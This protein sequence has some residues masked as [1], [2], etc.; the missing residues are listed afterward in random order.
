MLHYVIRPVAQC[1]RF[2]QHFFRLVFP[3][4]CLCSSYLQSSRFVPHLV[5]LLCLSPTYLQ[6]S[7]FV[8]GFSACPQPTCKAAGLCMASSGFSACPQ[9]N[10]KAADLW[11]QLV[12]L[13][14]FD[15]SKGDPIGIYATMGIAL[16]VI[17]GHTPLHN[18]KVE[19]IWEQIVWWVSA[20]AGKKTMLTY[21]MF[22]FALKCQNTN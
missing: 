20:D 1:I 13:L 17:G 21:W 19:R 9:P 2:R 11:I 7:K 6:G 18:T 5:W 12:W 4:L 16:W 22:S 8:T 3:S 15:L 14:C 10:C